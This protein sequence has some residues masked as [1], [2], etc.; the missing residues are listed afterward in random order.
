M[1]SSR[2]SRIE[3][4]LVAALRP[5]ELL[6][7]DES[8]RHGAHREVRT[9]SGEVLHDHADHPSA[10]QPTGAMTSGRLEPQSP[11]THFKILVA[12]S[13]FSGLSRVQRQRRIYDLLAT[14][15]KTGLHA[16]TLRALTP[17]EHTRG[18][19]EGF[20]SPACASRIKKNK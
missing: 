15:L 12:S 4:I 18:V 1:S 5:S 17:E 16:L 9:R 2:V 3:E 11:E 7:E 6:I 8:H 10:L 19:G 14:E 13:E 20:V